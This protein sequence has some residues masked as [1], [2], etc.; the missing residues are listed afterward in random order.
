MKKF[1]ISLF[2]LLGFCGSL[3]TNSEAMRIA[4]IP[5]AGVRQAPIIGSRI[6]TDPR[7][8]EWADS[9]MERM[10]LKEKI[11]QLLVYKFAPQN[12]RSNR[13]LIQRVIRQYHIG[14]VLFS[15]G[16]L[17]S[18]AQLT[19]EAQSHSRIPLMVTLDGEWGLAMR[20]KPTPVFPRNRILGCIANDSLIYEYGREVA[21]ECR[22][23]GIT[24]NFAPVADVDNNADNPVINVRSFGESRYNVAAKVVAYA[25]GLEDGG[26][27]A[28][29]KHFPGHGDTNVDS[30]KALPTLGFDRQRL[31]SIE[32]YPFR[33][34]IAAG[35]D[36][37]MVGHLDVPALSER[38]G[39]PSSLSQSIVTGL[40][41]E[42]L[43]FTG[44]KFTDAL[45]MKGVSGNR[46][47]CLQAL[48]A[49]NDL[50]LVPAR[51]KEEFE[52]IERA[53]KRGE[54]SEE[55][56]NAKCRKVL[57][58]K[59]VL[60]LHTKPHIQ[61]SGLEQRINTPAARQL[62]ERLSVEAV[63]LLGNTSHAVPVDTDV[64]DVALLNVGGRSSVITP[65]VDEVSTYA[66][67]TVLNVDASTTATAR[68]DIL[69]GLKDYK[70]I[71][72][73]LSD[74]KVRDYAPFLAAIPAD[75]P[76]IIYVSFVPA[77]EMMQAEDALRNAAAV[78][79]AHDTLAAVQVRAADVLYGRQV[80]GGR[81]STSLGTLY[82]VG[83]GYKAPAEDIAVE[84]SDEPEPVYRPED[85]G[86]DTVRLA[87]IDSI[88]LEG[89]AR[90]AYPGCQVVV[91]KDGHEVINRTYG[92]HT[93]DAGALP[94]ISTD[95]YDL[96]SL[97]KTTGTLLAVMKLFD[98]TRLNIS[99]YASRYL[100][101]LQG[102]DKR[103]IT[104]SD[105]L[106]HESGLPA[107]IP[108]YREAIDDKS[109]RGSLF[110]SKR[111]RRH[112]VQIERN[113]WATTDF[114]FKAGLTS[115]V[116]T[117]R[118]TLQVC[119]SLWI[120]SR[121]GDSIY[122]DKI[123]KARRGA[124]RYVYSD[125]NFIV[126]QQV[127]EAITGM[128]LDEYL[129]QEFFKPMGLKR[130]FYLA[131]QHLPKDEIVPTVDDAFL[132]RRLLHGYVHDE[133]AAFKG[134]VS[135]NAGLFS[136]AAEVACVYQMLLD[137]GVWQGRRYLSEATCRMFTT[138]TSR[139]SRRGLGFD[140]PAPD[141]RSNPCADSAPKSVYG[142]TGFT[143]TCAWVDPDS[144]MVYVFL[145]NRVYPHPWVNR[146]SSLNIRPRIQ[147][148]LYDAL[149][150]VH[151]LQD[152]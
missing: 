143:G 108:F 62:I 137:G 144:R 19:N 93:Y 142:H 59:Y 117:A 86:F 34:A 95:V 31:D 106:M 21:R 26:V 152:M 40:L 56:V 98:E 146:L 112:T 145:S 69:S 54:V 32:M 43:Q 38:S 60:G 18:Q 141:S 138:V 128:P 9:L 39:L 33:R 28:V 80:A 149:G 66:V 46:S 114:N 129:E 1:L 8:A 37:I 94:V 63:T 134:G 6:S 83:D 118:H 44:L 64:K 17:V 12:T 75:A 25:R 52:A 123:A 29:A 133:A 5:L 68:Q 58:Y 82:A 91:F 41:E 36:G 16:N 125:I 88:A 71:I 73:C 96:A 148:A 90:K 102:T 67:P 78:I 97:S 130:T 35:I 85:Y 30:H 23:M 2:V 126:L 150:Q 76:T 110:A 13:Q 135:G 49:G 81:L 111:D 147:Q 120:D 53:V 87:L 4:D 100:P 92:H 139:I 72:V 65:F 99:D 14:G 127:V 124:R 51:L 24:V 116:S 48:K 27:V 61:V 3:S 113:L 50:L 47:A 10:S 42:E 109:Y 101:Y 20:L 45:E 140:K 57:M 103:T 89:I 15:G 22:E 131:A 55:L 136:N 7:A 105:L 77:K 107:V 119:D 104:I 11:G 74:R 70:R 132:R 84:P 122:C 121:F 115:P 79:L 151:T